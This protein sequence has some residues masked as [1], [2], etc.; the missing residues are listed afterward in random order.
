MNVRRLLQFEDSEMGNQ[1]DTLDCVELL[2]AMEL[3][4]EEISKD[5]LEGNRDFMNHEDDEIIQLSE[6]WIYGLR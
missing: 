2:H 6:K 5:D 3:D 4:E 1:A